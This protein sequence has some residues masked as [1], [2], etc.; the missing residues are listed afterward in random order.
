MRTK[1][2]IFF[3]FLIFSH[4]IYSSSLVVSLPI[5]IDR[6]LSNDDFIYPLCALETKREDFFE[7]PSSILR[8]KRDPNLKKN[9]FISNRARKAMSSY[10]LPFNHPKRKFLDS[11]FLKTRATVDEETFLQSGFTII[12]KRP[13]S[14]IC[15][16]EHPNLTGYLV[17]VYLD[18]ELN[19][20][21]HKQSWEWLVRRCEGANKIRQVIADLNIRHFVVPDK[22][23]Y[24]FPAEP[25]PPDDPQHTRHLALLLVRRMKLTSKQRN[26]YA[27]S[28]DITT[29]HLDELFEIISRAK[30]SSYRPDNI[31]YLKNGQFAF[32]DTEYPTQGPDFNGIRKHLNPE[33]RNYW[34]TIVKEGGYTIA[35]D[36]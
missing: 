36:P 18:T 3:F 31:A 14:Y 10:M 23:I 13:R 9:L 11:I 25:S 22:W 19:Q 32:I 16:A 21:F 12:F 26:Y 8:S 1:I 7:W 5:S 20:K 6:K 29:E 28:H 15:V 34:D 35:D 17:K 30:G 4:F 24:C 33:M 2:P 27:W